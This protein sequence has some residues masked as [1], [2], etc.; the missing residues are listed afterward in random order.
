MAS[1]ATTALSDGAWPPLPPSSAK[2][3]PAPRGS[4]ARGVRGVGWRARAVGDGENEAPREPLSAVKA[5][6]S[7]RRAKRRAGA[8]WHACR[9]DACPRSS[10]LRGPCLALNRRAKR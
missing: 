8:A 5:R 3:A 2:A 1:P 4:G 7:P 6:Q 9:A 10:I